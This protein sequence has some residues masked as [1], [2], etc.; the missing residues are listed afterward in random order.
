MAEQNSKKL[1]TRRA[2]RECAMK[3]FFERL[4]NG[5]YN[6]LTYEMLQNMLLDDGLEYFERL[7]SDV[8]EKFDFLKQTIASYAVKYDANRIYKIDLSILILATNEILFYQDIPDKVA[9]NEAIEI[10]KI[11]S[12]D[13]SPAFIN[14]VLG[15]IVKDADK[16]RGEYESNVDW[17]KKNFGFKESGN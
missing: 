7:V 14:G 6:D 17:W 15:A 10:S 2:S 3:F 11:Y 5:S 12:T 16:I 13:N 8:N 9:I 4:V 1:N